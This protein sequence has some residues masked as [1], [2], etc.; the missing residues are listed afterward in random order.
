M[1]TKPD[2]VYEAAKAARQRSG[3]G[4]GPPKPMS[5]EM[6]RRINDSMNKSGIGG[7]LS[8]ADTEKDVVAA[9][10][11]GAIKKMSSGGSASRRAD[12]IAQRG[13]TRA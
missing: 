1:A 4:I 8:E 10:K 7:K 2:P 3:A 13:K 5:D 11:G 6:V 12:G 9:R